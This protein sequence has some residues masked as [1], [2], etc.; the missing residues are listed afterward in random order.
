M[1][2]YYQIVT[3]ELDGLTYKSDVPWGGDGTASHIHSSALFRFIVNSSLARKKIP[4]YYSCRCRNI[5]N[6]VH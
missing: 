4:E 1:P 2:E 3:I 6:D 5:G